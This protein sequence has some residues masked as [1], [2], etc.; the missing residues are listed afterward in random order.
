MSPARGVVVQGNRKTS[1]ACENP[2]F[3]VFSQD[4]RCDSDPSTNVS[5][6]PR[7]DRVRLHAKANSR[8]Y[9]LAYV[10]ARPGQH[11]FFQIHDSRRNPGIRRGPFGQDS[12]FCN[13]RRGRRLRRRRGKPSD[14]ASKFANFPPVFQAGG[15][16]PGRF[17]CP[18]RV[19]PQAHPPTSEPPP[20]YSEDFH[21][22]RFAGQRCRQLTRA[23]PPRR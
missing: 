13:G 16:P 4:A 17:T 1:E 22:E 11:L 15:E 23:D 21:L 5:P 9:R 20:I 2:V 8:R 14:F 10:P 19:K 6:W 7:A 12:R 3:T 18:L